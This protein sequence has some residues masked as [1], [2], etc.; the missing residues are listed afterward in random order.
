MLC[1]CGNPCKVP[2]VEFMPL[3][4][5]LDALLDH[6]DAGAGGGIYDRVCALGGVVQQLALE[7]SK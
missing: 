4:V 6:E 5:S 7:G 3:D 1:P 2:L